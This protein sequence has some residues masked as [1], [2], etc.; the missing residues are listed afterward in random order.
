MAETLEPE[1]EKC[2]RDSVAGRAGTPYKPSNGTEGM[3]FIESFC[4][5]CEKDRLYRE[6]CERGNPDGAVGCDI[7]ARTMLYDI[8][9]EQYPPEFTHGQ[10]GWPT[11]TAFESEKAPGTEPAT[12]RCSRT[13][14]MF[15]DQPASEA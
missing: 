12:Q 5:R 13:A 4:D 7:L 1:A 2:I 3:S 11:C 15:G 8:G 10:D 9:D 6:A 14:D